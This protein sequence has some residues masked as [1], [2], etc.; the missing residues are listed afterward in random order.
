LIAYFCIM[1]SVCVIIGEDETPF[2]EKI[3]TTP[4]TWL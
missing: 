4:G 2:Q 3:V 1:Y